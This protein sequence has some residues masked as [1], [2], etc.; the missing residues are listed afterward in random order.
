M[1]RPTLRLIE[2]IAEVV[3]F[4]ALL[5]VSFVMNQPLW[6][7]FIVGVWLFVSALFLVEELRYRVEERRYGRRR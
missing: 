3:V 2:A 5:W 7:Q 1:K 6:W 4:S